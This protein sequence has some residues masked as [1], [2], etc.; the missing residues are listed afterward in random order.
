MKTFAF[1]VL[2][3]LTLGGGLSFAAA[4]EPAPVTGT[5]VVTID[6]TA[7][8]GRVLPNPVSTVTIWGNFRRADYPDFVERA[9]MFTATGGNA[10]R[11][12][13]ADPSDATRLDDYDFT[14]LLTNCRNALACGITPDLHLGNV[15]VKFTKGCDPRREKAGG[16]DGGSYGFNIRPPDDYAVYGAYMKAVA[17]AL[18]AEFGRDAVRRWRFSVLT[19]ANNRHW[20]EAKDGTAESTK[21]AFFKLYDHTV[22]AFTDV[23]GDD[24]AIGTHLLATDS[25]PEMTTFTY[26]D[27]IA[28]CASGANDAT[29]G[30][31]APLNLLAFSY[32]HDHP[33]DDQENP[34]AGRMTDFATLRSALDAAGFTRAVVCMDEGRVYRTN[35]SGTNEDELVTRAVG[36]SWQAAFDVRAAKSAFDHGG[37]GFASWGHLAGPNSLCHG[38]PTVSWFAARELAKFAGMRRLEASVDA[39]LASAKEQVDAIAAVS[40]NGVRVRLALCRFRDKLV[41]RD[42]VSASAKVTLPAAMR[43]RTVT[44]S[45][46]AVDDTN[47][48]FSD[49][50]ADRKAYSIDAM[51]FWA[52]QDDQSPLATLAGAASRT[53]FAETLGPKYAAKAAS[54]V[55]S[56]Q[57]LAVPEDGVAL[58][59]FTLVGNAAVFAE[60]RLGTVRSS[61]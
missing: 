28:H 37:D 15:P 7:M 52:S 25:S 51:C 31:G 29:G 59:P 1:A 55:P 48:W 58:L 14:R 2:S 49:W 35:N 8:S 27:F 18:V 45:S 6:A 61:E 11:D 12:L 46:L 26:G 38:F 33:D 21:A 50:L 44:L 4:D 10:G 32:Y 16:A 13:F 20:F 42:R 54:V 19:E 56:V 9:V 3:V 23:L 5:A 41:F 40:D 24:V 53:L 60:I 43:G 22:K 30:T 57:T 36:Q 17:N 47:N 39:K 34:S